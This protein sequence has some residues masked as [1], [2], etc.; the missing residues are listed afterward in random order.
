[1]HLRLLR[2]PAETHR[3][4]LITLTLEKKDG[5]DRLTDGRTPGRCFTFSAV[6]AAS[7]IIIATHRILAHIA[8][9]WDS[10]LV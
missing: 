9:S 8:A 7:V 6:D 2:I 3:T 1:V 10:K 4:V 5:A